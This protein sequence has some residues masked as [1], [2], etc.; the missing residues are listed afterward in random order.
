MPYWKQE[1]LAQLQCADSQ[2][3]M[4]ESALSLAEQLGMHYMGYS[5][6][7]RHVTLKPQTL[8]FN[9]YPD[10]WNQE[11][12]AEG[13]FDI[14]PTVE[15]CRNSL[16][17]VLWSNDLFSET[18]QLREASI[19]FGLQHG[20]SLAVHDARGNESMLSVARSTKPI[21]QEEFYDKAGQTM[22]L[23]NLLHNLM[24]DQLF[25]QPTNKFH[26]TVREIEVLK[27]SA[28]GK[29]ADDIACIL[30]LSKSTVNFHIRSFITKLDTNN[31]TSAVAIAARHGL[32]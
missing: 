2:Q 16:L 19:R 3:Q 28:E 7:S 4:F 1:Q 32:L 23:C 24:A 13:Y 12:Q 22:W 20:W 29:T 18:P 17:P 14:D 15:H 6:R 21:E 25:Q 8:L 27:W 5:I 30:S 9:N 26:L 10:A 31:K 11:Y